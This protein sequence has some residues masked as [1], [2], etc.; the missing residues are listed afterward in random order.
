[1]HKNYIYIFCGLAFE[2]RAYT[3][4]QSTSSFLVIGF[5]KKRFCEL[6]LPRLASNHDPPDLC[7]WSS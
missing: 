2:L 5:F 1:M 7:F 6:Y 3:L 4:S